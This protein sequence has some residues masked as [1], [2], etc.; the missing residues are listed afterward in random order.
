[1]AV[2]VH[3]GRPSEQ[4]A[5]LEGLRGLA[6]GLVLLAHAHVPGLRAGLF[7]VDIFFVLSGYL[8]TRT[9]LTWT[10]SGSGLGRR[11]VGFLLRRVARL[12]PA[13]AV[14]LVLAGAWELLDDV[15]RG[16]TCLALAATYLMNLPVGDAGSCTG[17]LHITWSLAAEQQFYLLW[18]LV[19]IALSAV[20][21]PA[22]RVLMAYIGLVVAVAVVALLSPRIGGELNYSPLGRPLALLPGAALALA[23]PAT[24]RLRGVGWLL[25]AGLL[26]V[27]LLLATLPQVVLG[28]LVALP[29]VLL[30]RDLRSGP[31]RVRQA[32]RSP[33]LTHLGRISYSL[34]LVHLLVLYVTREVVPGRAAD[35]LGCALALALAELL[36]R[37][38]EDPLRRRGYALVRR[39]EARAA[40]T[41]AQRPGSNVDAPA[42]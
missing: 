15:D 16:G 34:Y 32:L 37:L 23:G 3:A 38:V 21:R 36:H 35:V 5:D 41:Q 39:L 11:Y 18:P 26:A 13:L 25:P 30:M 6:I 40:L 17:P 28:P 20:V 29:A 7:G 31:S 10:S 22:R 2:D 27:A 14:A 4:F 8:I 12:V 19:L 33:V 24:G 9:L 42:L 1:M